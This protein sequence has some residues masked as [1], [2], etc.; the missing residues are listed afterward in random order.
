MHR[1]AF[2]EGY[3][4]GKKGGTSRTTRSRSIER[5][6]KKATELID[7]ETWEHL[8]NYNLWIECKIVVSDDIRRQG[9][10]TTR[11]YCNCRFTYFSD[12]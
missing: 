6:R 7:I 3:K 9:H 2:I 1:E 8:L 5:R 11:C 12:H 10:I 4:K